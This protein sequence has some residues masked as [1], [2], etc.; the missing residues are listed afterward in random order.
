MLSRLDLG[1]GIGLRPSRSG[2]RDF[3][4]MVHNASRWDLWLARSDPELIH[5][6]VGMQYE[7][8]LWG[9][10]EQFPEALYY[11]IERADTACGRLVLDFSQGMVHVIDMALVSE[12]QG[13]GI[14]QRVVQAVQNV[15][16]QLGVPVVLMAQVM[17]TPALRVYG[18]LGFQAV[19]RPNA[20]FVWLEWR[21]GP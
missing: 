1:K 19:D 4:R 10:G 3:E 20:A 5:S 9:Y 8:Q 14:G 17:N 7:A 15:A 6:L 18:N 11:I 2:D 16:L 12:A 13:R 21:P